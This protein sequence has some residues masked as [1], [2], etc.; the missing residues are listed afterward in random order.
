[1]ANPSSEQS[2]SLQ[3]APA[4]LRTVLAQW[5]I[6]LDSMNAA[7][8]AGLHSGTPGTAFFCGY[9]AAM[10]C[11][12]PALPA[13]IWAAFCISESGMKS[14]RDMT[15]CYSPQEGISGRKSHV[16]LAGKGLDTLYVVARS[17]VQEQTELLCLKVSM[18]APGVNCLEA[19]KP[20]PFMPDVPHVPVSLSSVVADRLVSSDA[21]NELNRP[22][23]YWEDM[24]IAVALAGWMSAKLGGNGVLDEQA[25][26]LR[27]AFQQQSREYHLAA[28]DAYEALITQ[29]EMASVGL[30]GEA[31]SQWQRDRMLLLMAAPLCNKIRANFSSDFSAPPL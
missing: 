22:F 24:H 17:Q 31:A 5:L 25:M 12:D 8:T 14:L 1:M 26:C 2:V 30:T 20:Q 27:D 19:V 23:R 21:H 4:A 10:R 11:L 15:T 3:A 29:M 28:L 13:D 6:E 9:Q 18:Q 16:M 7:H